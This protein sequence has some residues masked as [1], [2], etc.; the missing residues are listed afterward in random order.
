MSVTTTTTPSLRDLGHLPDDPALLKS[1]LAELLELLRTSRR[2]NDQLQ[3]RLDQLLRRLYGRSA[4]RVDP[5]QPL[6]FPELA[7]E[8]AT[9]LL[10]AL[11]AEPEP[12]A[13]DS[14]RPGHGRHK[15]PN[16]LPRDVRVYELSTA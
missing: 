10:A 1:M 2:E 12:S 14:R 15:L 7:E 6:L 8:P 5:N 4:E 13:A 3:A 16:H 9:P 11:A